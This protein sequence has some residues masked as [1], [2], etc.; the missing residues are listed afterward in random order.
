MLKEKYLEH[1]VNH[2]GKI[3]LVMVVYSGVF[4][5]LTFFS[6]YIFT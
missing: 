5:S 1:T 4:V 3:K 6:T 2:Q